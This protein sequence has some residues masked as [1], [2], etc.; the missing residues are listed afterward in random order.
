MC[1]IIRPKHGA[2]LHISQFSLIFQPLAQQE[3]LPCRVLYPPSRRRKTPI[4][5]GLYSCPRPPATIRQPSLRALR[6]TRLRS[7]PGHLFWLCRSLN[8]TEADL[9]R[10]SKAVEGLEWPVRIYTDTES[11]PTA[12]CQSQL[13]T[14]AFRALLQE[15]APTVNPTSGPLVFLTPLQDPHFLPK[16]TVSELTLFAANPESH[17]QQHKLVILYCFRLIK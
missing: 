9:D 5:R 4:L 2:L 1:S 12:I 14:P 7:R 15:H 3:R 13:S 16:F 11:F 6:Q 17:Y 10:V 8:I